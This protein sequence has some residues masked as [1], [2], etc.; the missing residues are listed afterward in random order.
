[1]LRLALY[2]PAGT[3]GTS[4]S[5]R[6]MHHGGTEWRDVIGGALVTLCAD[7]N[8]STGTHL[9]PPVGLM[10][11]RT[12]GSLETNVVIH[13]TSKLS[14]KP[15]RGRCKTPEQFYFIVLRPDSSFNNRDFTGFHGSPLVAIHP[16]AAAAVVVILH[17]S[18]S[19]TE[20]TTTN[21]KHH[22]RRH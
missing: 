20:R 13:H 10:R 21:L 5:Q 14:P 17:P 4:L 7:S 22:D 15:P 1:M 12:S 16:T 11:K 19:T 9:E 18:S 3:A 2:V 6:F 8:A